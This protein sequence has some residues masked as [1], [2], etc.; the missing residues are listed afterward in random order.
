MG[1]HTSRLLKKL[2][3]AVKL[4]GSYSIRTVPSEFLHAPGRFV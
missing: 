2:N 4:S 1:H 3:F